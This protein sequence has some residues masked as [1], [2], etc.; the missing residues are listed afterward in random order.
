MDIQDILT[1]WGTYYRDGGQDLTRVLKK[2]YI[3][4]QTEALFGLIPTDDTS[5]QMAIAEL[6]RVL[7]PFQLG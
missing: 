1:E 3:S 7:Q 5:Y 6:S 2:P 4:S